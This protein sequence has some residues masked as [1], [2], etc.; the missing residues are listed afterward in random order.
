MTLNAFNAMMQE[1]RDIMSYAFQSADNDATRAT[2]L[3]IAKY[4]AD[5]SRDIAATDAA[6]SKSSGFWG[7]LGSVAA[8]IL[9]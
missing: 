4:N 9:R 5:S 3:A 8:A 2:N 7:A 6:A 1:S